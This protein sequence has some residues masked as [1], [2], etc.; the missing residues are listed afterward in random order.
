MPQDSRQIVL[1]DGVRFAVPADA[2]SRPVTG[3]DSEF[4]HLV[5]AGYEMTYDYGGFPEDL[6]ARS[7]DPG[8]ESSRRPVSGATGTQVHFVLPESPLPEV[9]ML[10]VEHRGRTLSLSVSC[11]DPELCASLAED[12]FGSVDLGSS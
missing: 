3:V 11:R 12:L 1:S 7:G 5:G 10:Q 8:Y 6:G 9:H 4:G 2:E